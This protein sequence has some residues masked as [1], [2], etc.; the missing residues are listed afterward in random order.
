MNAPL[1]RSAPYRLGVDLGTTWT[2]AAVGQ[3]DQVEV[4][5]LGTHTTAMPSVVALAGDDVLAGERAERQLLADPTSGV[6]ECKR[7]LGDATPMVVGGRPFV[8]EALMSALLRHV[9]AAATQQMGAAPAEIVLTHPATWGEYKLDLV[10]QAARA[11]SANTNASANA[12]ANSVVLV[13]EPVAAALHYVRLGKIRPGDSVAVY[14]FGGGTFDAAVVRCTE[15]GGEVLGQ[16]EGLERLGGVDLD[17]VVVAHVDAAL[18]GRLRELAASDPEVRRALTQLRADCTLAKEA[19]SNDTEATVPVIVPGLHTEVRITRDE[20]ETATRTRVADTLGALDRA[21]AASGVAVASLA[22]VLL[23]GGSSRIPVVGEEVAR[24][25]ARP[26]LLDADPKLV[27]ALGAAGGTTAMAPVKNPGPSV[28][29]ARTAAPAAPAPATPGASRPAANPAS[30]PAS[31]ASPA[32]PAAPAA[33]STSSTSSSSPATQAAEKAAALRAAAAREGGAAKKER[34][35]RGNP[36]AFA[37]V[38]TAAAGAAAVGYAATQLIGDDEA[39][40]A[41]DHLDAPTHDD[42]MDAFD[43]VAG[44]PGGRGGARGGY[45]RASMHAGGAHGA[46]APGAPGAPAHDGGGMPAVADISE[47]RAELLERLAA[48]E[49]PEGA[50]DEDVAEFRAELEGI[51]NRFQPLPGQSANDALASLRQQFD[52]HVKDFVQDV[53]LDAVI[54][55]HQNEGMPE[56][57]PEPRS[58]FEWVGGHTDASG[59]YVPGH[60]ERARAPQPEDTKDDDAPARTW[61]DGHYD[62]HGNYVKG[63]WEDGDDDPATSGPADTDDDAPDMPPPPVVVY[64]SDPGPPVVVPPPPASGP[65]VRDHRHGYDDDDAHGGVRVVAGQPRGGYGNAEVHDHRGGGDVTGSSSIFDKLDDVFN[66]ALDKVGDVFTGTIEPAGD[67]SALVAPPGAPGA[68]GYG[69]DTPGLPDLAHFAAFPDA[70]VPDAVTPDAL[71]ALGTADGP[72]LPLDA[73]LAHA[74]GGDDLLGVHAFAEASSTTPSLDLAADLEPVA[75]ALPVPEPPV[76]HALD[77]LDPADALHPADAPDATAVTLDHD[78]GHLA[79]LVA[80]P[81]DDD[82]A[83]AI[84]ADEHD[85]DDA[86]PDTH[87]DGHDDDTPSDL[88]SDP[89]TPL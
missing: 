29:P 88:D 45:G 11:A 16:P 46:P 3:R 42:S 13:P 60:W 10:R 84:V 56:P 27:V 35:V 58:G 72:D 34:R 69:G 44:G 80:D 87:D 38:A 30:A 24:H 18:D 19:L 31:P 57:M 78:P 61:V 26:I 12:S 85:H 8:A 75:P 76:D 82:P 77:A 66:D 21:I 5:T 52:D 89:H 23:V 6:R 40:A 50:D 49:P 7:R 79:V 43:D 59:Q 68:H 65:I 48:W 81:V 54:E 1:D 2:A 15:H 9:V 55:E 20:F 67:A 73:D 70:I 47:A 36:R 71:D 4:L 53:K 37:G 39:S 62:E 28:P 32:S 25:T 14:D 63:H 83:L 86:L 51:I 74:A 64:P 17:Q 33:P 41:T 22:G